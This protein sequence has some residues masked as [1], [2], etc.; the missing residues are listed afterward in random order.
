MGMKAQSPPPELITRSQAMCLTYEAEG[1]L[2]GAMVIYIDSK[3]VI[4]DTDVKHT[5]FSHVG[6]L[7]RR[8]W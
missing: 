7:S 3:S 6:G 4:C 1:G 5:G 8:C 2:D